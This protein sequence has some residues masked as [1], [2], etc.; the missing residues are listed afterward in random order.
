MGFSEETF[1]LVP[2]GLTECTHDSSST[3]CTFS[4][5]SLRCV[6]LYN[7][8]HLISGDPEVACIEEFHSETV[9]AIRK[10]YQTIFL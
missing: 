9:I 4:L 3:G 2:P 10:T 1:Q 6:S 7:M 8:C 5:R